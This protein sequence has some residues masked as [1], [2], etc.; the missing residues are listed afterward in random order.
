M[1]RNKELFHSKTDPVPAL[2]GDIQIIP[3]EDKG[4]DLLYFHDSMGYLSK[5]FA[6]DA[7]IHPLL[8]MLNGDTSIE[9]IHQQ[10]DGNI[11]HDN[12]LDFVQLLDQHRALHSDYFRFF[13]DQME[14][15]F[16]KSH[17]RP[18]VLAGES[19]PNDPEEI[20]TYVSEIISENGRFYDQSPQA[21]YAPHIELSV[22]KKLYGEAFA[23]LNNSEPKRVV[24]LA[25]SHYADYYY[26]YYD[27]FP[28]IG[29]KKAFQ[30]PGRS[31]IPDIDLIESLNEKSPENGF[32]LKDR[33]HRIEHS[34]EFHL[35]FAST[36]WTHDFKIVPILVSNFD[37]LYYK[38][39][40]DLGQK[41]EIFTTQLKPFVD[42][43]TMVLISGDL[44]HVGQK[45]G[46]SEPASSLR[47]TVEESDKQLLDISV[48]GNPGE[49]LNH[50]KKDYD[51]TRICGFPPLYTYLRMFPDKKGELLNYY[52]WDE[53]ERN[54]AVSFGSI[55]Y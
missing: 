29:S 11:S 14:V 36:I 38:E 55:L 31:L 52:W 45:F 48:T 5:N 50:L 49:L 27:G 6:L 51:S 12:L 18:H 19:Y 20:K 41:I 32:T 30:M 8:Q 42:E 43:D 3:I 16:E 35:L 40:G 39:D 26:K 4:R 33:A 13:A 54:S 34:I 53:K 22:G 10:V 2:R 24:I 37:D 25:T 47:E 7:N 44:S 9:H 1:L 28:F 15:D 21:L 17:I 23:H 46:D